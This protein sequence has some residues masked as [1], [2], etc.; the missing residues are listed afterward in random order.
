MSTTS[1]MAVAN[2]FTVAPR[3]FGLRRVL[4]WRRG[5]RDG[6]LA[7]E[8]TACLDAGGMANRYIEHWRVLFSA[9][10][11]QSV[12][13][14]DEDQP[15]SA[16]GASAGSG[17]AERWDPGP[18]DGGGQGLATRRRCGNLGW[19]VASSSSSA[20]CG[21]YRSITVAQVLD[22]GAIERPM[23]QGGQLTTWGMVI[24]L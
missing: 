21:M 4:A 12:S 20:G 1:E 9:V 5:A 7:P 11:A 17:A 10:L 23:P 13:D 19:R 16:L 15:G 8:T 2:D 24:D 18:F 22:R 3:V 14:L 6:P